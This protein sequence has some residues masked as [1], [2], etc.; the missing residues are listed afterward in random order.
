[1]P[2]FWAPIVIWRGWVGVGRGYL[3]RWLMITF[4]CSLYNVHMFNLCMIPLMHA[5]RTCNNVWLYH[6][7]YNSSTVDDK[8]LLSVS[9]V[10]CTIGVSQCLYIV[11]AKKIFS[12]RE[13]ENRTNASHPRK[14]LRSSACS[15]VCVRWW[16][17]EGGDATSISHDNCAWPCA[18][19]EF[20]CGLPL[21][22]YSWSGVSSYVIVWGVLNKVPMWF[23]L[24]V[25][26]FLPPVWK[27]VLIEY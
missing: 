15:F 23:S 21:I 27:K 7:L 20:N 17:L 6:V 3:W 12:L 26:T 8:D 2:E 18:L 13:K 11:Q 24:Y 4:T 5:Q 14:T 9:T 1:M 16:K 10:K 19:Q 25:N 22:E